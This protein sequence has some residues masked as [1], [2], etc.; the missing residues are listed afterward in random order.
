MTEFEKLVTPHLKQLLWYIG[1]RM[2]KK[3]RGRLDAEDILQNTLITA[4]RR[5]K[6]YKEKKDVDFVYWINRIATDKIIAAYRENVETSSRSVNKEH[7]DEVSHDSDSP[8]NIMDCVKG[9]APNPLDSLISSDQASIINEVLEQ[10]KPSD[11][12]IIV[13]RYF[14]GLTNDEI[15]D[16]IGVSVFA[17]SMRNLRALRRLQELT[18]DNQQI[19]DMICQK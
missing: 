9:N 8:P 10:M 7:K 17:V 3:I 5:F 12:E 16:I 4:H 14:R 6:K 19:M 11:K 15:A 13:M 1:Q 18:K 2:S